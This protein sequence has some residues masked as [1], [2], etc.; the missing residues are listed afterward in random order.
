MVAASALNKKARRNKRRAFFVGA[1]LLAK[2]SG[3]SKHLLND[4]RLS[5][6]GSHRLFVFSRGSSGAETGWSLS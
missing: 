2:A 1:S 6:A 3:Q 5:R 4:S